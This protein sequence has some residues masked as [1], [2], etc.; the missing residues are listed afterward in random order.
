MDAGS[1][2]VQ[3]SKILILGRRSSLPEAR[4]VFKKRIKP[5]AYSFSQTEERGRGFY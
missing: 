4:R 2:K 5:A 1:R 3:L